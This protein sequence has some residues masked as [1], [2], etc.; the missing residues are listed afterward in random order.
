MAAKFELVRDTAGRSRFHLKVA[1]GGIIAASR[2]STSMAAAGLDA[3]A[4]K[5]RGGL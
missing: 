4:P 3:S 2:G 1:G 5:G